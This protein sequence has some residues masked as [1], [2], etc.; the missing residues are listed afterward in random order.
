MDLSRS[1]MIHLFDFKLNNNR[2]NKEDVELR[3]ISKRFSKDD[4]I[5]DNLLNARFEKNYGS[6]D[7]KHLQIDYVKWKDW[8]KI[9]YR[10]EIEEKQ[11][12]RN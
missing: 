5:I 11:Y 9:I 8:L 2:N 12:I 7:F 4:R 10:M 3:R 6:I 1:K